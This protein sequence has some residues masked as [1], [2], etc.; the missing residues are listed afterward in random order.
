MKSEFTKG[1][2]DR[3]GLSIRNERDVISD[4]TLLKLQE[5]RTS[6]KEILSL[7]FN[8]LCKNSNKI[9]PQT[10]VTYRIKRIESIIGKLY[11][12]PD[13]R[14]SRMWDIGGCRCITRNNQDVYK[15]KNLIAQNPDFEIV[16][17]YDYIKEPQKDGYKSLHLFVKQNLC[18]KVIEV[19]IRNKKD[20]DWATLVE[21]T[22]LLYDS[23]LKE[24]G[25][26]PSNYSFKELFHFHFLL[27]KDSIDLEEK[28]VIASI[29][30]KYNYF[31]KLSEVFA[32]NI[33]KVRKQWLCIENKQSLKYFLIETT[34]DEVP[35]IT[36]FD[37]SSN[38]ERQYF[39]VYK[40]NNN[41]NIVLIH[42]QNP[43][44]NQICIAYSNYILTFHS[45]LLDCLILIENLIIEAIENKKL[46][47]YYK[48]YNLY[49]DLNFYFFRNLTAEITE[50]IKFSEQANG[51][52]KKKENE[53]IDDIKKQLS[54][55]K[56]R[57]DKLRK[58]LKRN[59]PDNVFYQI[60]IYLITRSI[61]TK[62]KNKIKNVK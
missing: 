1:D 56:D 14:F 49:S 4:E 13:M 51:K 54:I 8:F 36:S 29:I 27:S 61:N 12:Y 23:K 32:R 25:D 47:T 22:D 10:I 50:L 41:A 45:F 18:D 9:H 20:H 15:I 44:Y 33:F 5:Y 53:W 37:N 42:L 31:E 3:L 34:K 55:M 59:E 2:I 6:H 24:L 57:G 58:K 46:F 16:K 17:E 11:R 48:T 30:K 26:D 52:N 35:K 40:S 62:Y 19:Q 39:E 28:R 7:I 43:N 21:I 60:V 38:A